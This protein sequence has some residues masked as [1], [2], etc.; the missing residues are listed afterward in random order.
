MVVTFDNNLK[1]P[2]SRPA[3]PAHASVAICTGRISTIAQTSRGVAGSLK[4]PAP[5]LLFNHLR[6]SVLVSSFLRPQ[7]GEFLPAKV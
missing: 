4:G 1:R 3:S 5:T 2:G 6:R 7:Q